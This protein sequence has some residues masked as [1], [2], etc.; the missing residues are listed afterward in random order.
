MQSVAERYA[1]YRKIMSHL[2]HSSSRD[3][4]TLF[5]DTFHPLILKIYSFLPSNVF[6]VVYSIRDEYKCELSKGL[7]DIQILHVLFYQ[8]L[9]DC[10][11][12]RCYC[13]PV[14]LLTVVHRQQFNHFQITFFMQRVL[15][16]SL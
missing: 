3:P 8:N 1:A 7:L 10:T 16:I 5:L 6:D 9:T 15:L 11:A 14:G 2:A 4:F 12:R 13:L